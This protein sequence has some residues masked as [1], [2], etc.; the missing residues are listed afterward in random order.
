MSSGCGLKTTGAPSIAELEAA[1]MLPN[2]GQLA[3]GPCLC[4][5][6]IEEIPCNPCET[7]CPR[8]AIVVG[9]PITNLPV[10]DL[11]KCTACGLCIPACPG[12][13]VTIKDGSGDEAVIRFP[14]E[15]LPLPEAGQKVTMC[16][17][18]GEPVCEGTVRLVN[19]ATRN[20]R[21]AVV[22]AVF[23]KSVITEVIS[24][25]RLPRT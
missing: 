11:S 7:A 19:R 8:G 16:D 3:A 13:A 18:Q 14:Y 9:I 17:R 22:T 1:G 5:E 21:T 20:D 4:V 24:M 2:A 25:V 6:C 10:I 15:Y 23:D 12:L